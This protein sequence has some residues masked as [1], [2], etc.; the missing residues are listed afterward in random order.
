LPRIKQKKIHRLKKPTVLVELHD[1]VVYSKRLEE[2]ERIGE[3]KTNG[4]RNEFVNTS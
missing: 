4:Y 1:Y 3:K 2:V